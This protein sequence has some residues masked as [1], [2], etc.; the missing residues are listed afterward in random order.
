MAKDINPATLICSE[1]V[2]QEEPQEQAIPA[3]VN[4]STLTRVQGKCSA[5][6][7][8]MFRQDKT[9]LM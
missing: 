2:R 3:T 5:A 1:A 9:V 7:T 4:C 8:V 6:A